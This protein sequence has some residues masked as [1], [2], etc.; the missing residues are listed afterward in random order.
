MMTPV[1]GLVMSPVPCSMPIAM[2]TGVFTRFRVP[3]QMVA[4]KCVMVCWM[5][6][7]F[8]R[9]PPVI[10][11]PFRESHWNDGDFV[12]LRLLKIGRQVVS[13]L[14]SCYRAAE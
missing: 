4:R 8:R 9:P 5:T 12:T 2:T 10:V 14:S 13:V 1:A 11:V 7:R 6:V 3:I